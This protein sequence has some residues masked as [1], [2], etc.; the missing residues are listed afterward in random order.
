V[1]DWREALACT[2]TL[3]PHDQGP[4][5]LSVLP[6][7]SGATGMPKGCMHTHASILHN[8]VASSVW[9]NVTAEAVTLLV[10][11]MFHITGMVSGCTP[12]C[13]PGPPSC[14]CRAGTAT[15]RVGSSPLGA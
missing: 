12:R 4:D 13:I 1:S 8:A 7:T 14:S 11:P 2:D 5:D 3:S 10:V 9:G 15:W 6:Y